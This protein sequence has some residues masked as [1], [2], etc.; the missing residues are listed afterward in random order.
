METCSV[1]IIF[2]FINLVCIMVYDS[3]PSK[4]TNL[5][6]CLGRFIER[7]PLRFEYE[8]S[9]LHTI[10]YGGT[11]TGNTYYVRQYLKLYGQQTWTKGLGLILVCKAVPLI[12]KIKINL[13]KTK[14]TF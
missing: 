12:E 8:K 10:V 5:E 9:S 3:L 2:I 1:V 14:T 4:Y 13:K 11:G 7:R 6:E